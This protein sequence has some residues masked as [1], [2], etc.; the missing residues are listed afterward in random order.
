L[1]VA[2]EGKGAHVTGVIID[3]NSLQGEPLTVVVA[4]SDR[5]RRAGWTV[6]ANVSDID[7]GSPLAPLRFSRVDGL[8]ITG[9][10]Q[11]VGPEIRNASGIVHSGIA[12]LLERTTGAEVHDNDFG[13]ANH[14]LVNR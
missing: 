13:P 3:A 9:N 4:A 10:V 8:I 1:F 14:V 12:V 5:S 11:A 6:T 2:A 7:F